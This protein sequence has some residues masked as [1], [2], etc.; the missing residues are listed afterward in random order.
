MILASCKVY[1]NLNNKG[2]DSDATATFTIGAATIWVS[3][4][5]ENS[6]GYRGIVNV[7]EEIRISYSSDVR[8]YGKHL[9]PDIRA[10]KKQVEKLT[11]LILNCAHYDAR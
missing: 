11:E 2:F 5:Y 3:V 8:P 7:S 9:L 4:T 6:R 10:N 1:A